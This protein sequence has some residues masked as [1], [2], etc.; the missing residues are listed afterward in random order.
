MILCASPLRQPP[1]LAAIRHPCSLK[2]QIA[3]KY[4]GNGPKKLEFISAK[5]R[6]DTNNCIAQAREDKH[7]LCSRLFFD[8]QKEIFGEMY[9][10]TFK[11][12][13]RDHADR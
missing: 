3:V 11:T 12:L 2:C 10:V 6:D 1:E 7:I 13:K 8:V 5:V 4:L 9:E